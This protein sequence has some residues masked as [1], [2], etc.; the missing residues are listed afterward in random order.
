[1]TKCYPNPIRFSSVR[2]RRVE[3]AFSGGAIIGNGGIPLLAEVDQQLGLTC[4]VSKYLGIHGRSELHP[5]DLAQDRGGGAAQYPPHP[6]PAEQYLPLGKVLNELVQT[7]PR[8]C[9]VRSP[10]RLDTS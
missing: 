8:S 7:F 3:V 2:R 6:D 5:P 9:S 10:L 1:M 4:S